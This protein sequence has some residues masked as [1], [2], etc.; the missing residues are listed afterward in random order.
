MKGQPPGGQE[1]NDS[2]STWCLAQKFVS[3][4]EKATGKVDKSKI[5]DVVFLGP[6]EAF[7]SM[8]HKLIDRKVKALG[9][10]AREI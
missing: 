4:L 8:D 9:V 3:F 5:V 2:K 10:D 7:R 6:Q 1:A